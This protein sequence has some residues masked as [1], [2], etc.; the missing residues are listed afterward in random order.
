MPPATESGLTGRLGRLVRRDDELLLAV[1]TTVIPIVLLL[2]LARSVGADTWLA[3]VI[4]REIADHGIPRHEE[5]T[6]IVH[7]ARWVDQQW[8]AQ[9][10]TYW[11][12]QIGGLALIGVINVALITSGVAGAAAA[13]LKLGARARVVTRVLPLAAINVVIAN[14]VRTQPYAYPLFVCI[15]FLLARDSR[16][17]SRAVYWS[18][19]ALV[20]WANLHGS[21]VIGAGL[22]GLRGLVMLWERRD[23]LRTS[24]SQWLRPVALMAGGPVALLITPYG[25]RTVS[26]Y[27]DTLL[28]GTLR[29]IVSEWQPVT[30]AWQLALVF[31]L[32]AGIAVWSFGRYPSRTTMW[33]R[34]ALIA[35][36]AAGV[37]AVRNIVW[38]GMAAL[39]VLPLALEDA[40][41]EAPPSPSRVRVNVGLA[42]GM[43]G[44]LLV[45]TVFTLA[46][47]ES[48]FQKLYPQGALAAVRTAS[49]DPSVRVFADERYADWLLWR[50]PQLRGRVAYDARFEILGERRLK[51]VVRVKG[52]IGPDWKRGARGYRV[53]VLGT[54]L[55]DGIKGFNRE[56]G[57]RILYHHTGVEVFL[58]T[59][60]ASR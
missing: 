1:L 2:I 39:V 52:A 26:Y 8:L 49:A 5:L 24:A 36:T 60:A 7:G 47:P 46:R 9:L 43:G 13:S 55:T 59:A 40:F 41:G 12:N 18:L 28:N 38:L 50:L 25:L 27:K 19:P 22:I 21:A 51:R 4:G 42:A 37:S 54:S 3:L 23:A 29:K 20:V 15:F 48:A 57:R 11:F 35:L 14:E 6:T 53:I 34:C 44:L 58:R 32:L 33:E 10:L 45:A 16:R 31:F 17:P 56:A 30:T